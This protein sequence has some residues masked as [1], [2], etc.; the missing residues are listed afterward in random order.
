MNPGETFTDLDGRSWTVDRSLG[1]GTWSQSL[2]VRSRDGDDAV[3]RL[4]LSEVDI[5]GPD[6][7]ARAAACSE[8]CQQLATLLEA[9]PPWGPRL[10]GRATATDGRPLLLVRRYPST[11]ASRLDA[12]APLTEVLHIVQR[13]GSLLRESGRVHGALNGRN[14]LLDEAGRL[15]VDDLWTPAAARCRVAHDGFRPPEAAAAPEAGWDTWALCALLYRCALSGV[16]AANG[17]RPSPVRIP[18]AGLDKVAIATLKDRALSRLAAE[19][20]NPRFRGRLAERLG[21]MLNR[22]LSQQATP[23]PPYRFLSMSA[24]LERLSEVVALVEPRVDEVGRILLPQGAR[25][26]VFQ[27]GEAVSFAVTVATSTVVDTREDLVC[28]VA[29]Y[30]LDADGEMRVPVPEARYETRKHPSGRLRFAFT[31]PGVA[32]GRYRVRVA[33][34]VRDSGHQPTTAQGEFEIRPPPGWVPPAEEVAPAPLAFPGSTPPSGPAEPA[35]EVPAEGPPSTYSGEDA[36]APQAEV[37]ALPSPV[38]PPASTAPVSPLPRP[39]SPPATRP[40]PVEVE[41]D[42]SEPG[43]SPN[44]EATLPQARPVAV[45]SAAETSPFETASPGSVDEDPWGVP[46]RWEPALPDPSLEDAFGD[47]PLPGAH[48]GGEDL[49]GD[50]DDEFGAY[51]RDSPLERIY[52]TIRRDTYTSMVAVAAA[53][54]ILVLLL[55]LVLQSC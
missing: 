5:G 26:A 41:I 55:T 40:E 14:I 11:L 12:G 52:E 3:A 23:S 31:L 17:R 21:A 28:G 42:I 51:S 15:V 6:A 7:A 34:T 30:D 33:F 20:S 27:G 4:P 37:V 24:F 43:T 32:P 36:E 50:S 54:L 19:R 16:P 49:F 10:I 35:A 44:E 25:D 48:H 18:D 47:A 8:R 46:G 9:E 38:S 13:V 39:V 22:G 45:P 29:L 53:C 2:L 1:T